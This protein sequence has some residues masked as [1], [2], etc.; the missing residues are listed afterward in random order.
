MEPDSVTEDIG[1]KPK[2]RHRPLSRVLRDFAHNNT[3]DVSLGSLRTALGDR[4][5]AALL[6]VFSSINL[7]PIL[8]PGSTIVFGIPPLI[9]AVQMILGQKSVW[10]PKTLLDRSFGAERFKSIMRSVTPRLRRLEHYIKPRMWPFPVMLGERLVGVL[11]ALLS[12]LV[13]LPIPGANWIPAFAMVLMGLSLSQRDG[14]LLT[15]GLG[16]GIGFLLFLVTI[17]GT[18]ASFAHGFF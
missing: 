16:I 6:V 18:V 15:L 5:F 17:F 3:G 9:I 13:I 8:P 4:S 11:C 1:H 14:I 12:I 7:I 10:L 2:R